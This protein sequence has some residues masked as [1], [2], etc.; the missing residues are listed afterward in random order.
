M[1]RTL[2]ELPLSDD[3]DDY[4]L[5]AAACAAVFLCKRR[6]AAP[7]KRK[8]LNWER[9]V[10]RLNKEGQFKR[11]YQMLELRFEKPLGSN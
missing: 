1:S 2:L 7:H 4:G 11:M 9:H 3:V 6:W 10:M 8:R 5:I